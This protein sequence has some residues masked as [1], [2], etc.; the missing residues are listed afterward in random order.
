[1]LFTRKDIII[2]LMSKKNKAKNIVILGAGI[3]G[4]T[5]SYFLNKFKIKNMVIEKQN[6]CGG[7]LKS[8]KIKKHVFD[9]FIHISHAKNPIAKNFF[10]ASAKNFRIK[11]RPNNLY[12]NMWI[13]HSPQFH[14]FP[15]DFIEKIKIILSYVFRYRNDNF[16][17]KNYENWL[18]GTYGDYFAKHFPIAYTAKYWATKSRDMSTSWI[19]FRMQP[20][21]LKDLVIGAFFRIY[22]DTFY[23]SQM[24]YPMHGG[25]ES[26]LNILKRNK[27][28]KLNKKIKKINLRKKEIF[29]NEGKK[30][31]FSKLVSTIPLPEFCQL[32]KN[33]PPKI[34]KASKLLRCTAGILVSI[35]IKKKIKMRTWFY[36]YD[37]KIKAARVYSP[38]KLSKFNSPKNK[39]SLQAEIFVDN[40]E[41]V[42]REY[43]DYVK[44]NTVENLVKIGIFEKKDLEVVNIKFLKYANVIF[45]KNCSRNRSL[46]L[47]YFKKY[48]VDFVGRFGKWAYLWSDDCFLSGKLTAEKIYK[49]PN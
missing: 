10:K 27:S 4:L 21:N 33:I 7:L 16:K 38:S 42:T 22:K 25:Y 20:V 47:E 12:K 9:N 30:I 34:L 44:N 2:K 15:L 17:K 36:I 11:P 5:V 32:C 19:K 13:D 49:N 31:K 23:S 40:K 45:D 41:N 14:L 24:R 3:S 1:M 46:I 8:F 35:G 43:L 48:N 29:L 37:K 18:R 28:I 39:S 6:K 26:F